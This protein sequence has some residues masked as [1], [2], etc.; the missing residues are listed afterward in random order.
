[1]NNLSNYPKELQILLNKMNKCNIINKDIEIT[2]KCL[3]FN[4]YIMN[5]MYVLFSETLSSGK[6]LK[7]TNS[8]CICLENIPNILLSPCNHNVVCKSCILCLKTCP[9]CRTVIKNTYEIFRT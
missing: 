3:N 5:K 9:I 6:Q 8:C 4:D 2:I 1:M 7:Y